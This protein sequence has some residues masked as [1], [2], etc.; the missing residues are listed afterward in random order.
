MT[1][2]LLKNIDSDVPD[3][4]SVLRNGRAAVTRSLGRSPMTFCLTGRFDLK[5]R[6]TLEDS[7]T[8]DAASTKDPNMLRHKR[9]RELGSCMK[10]FE[11]VVVHSEVNHMVSLG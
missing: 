7:Q 8:H 4:N 3:I 1:Y 11:M 9:L 5:A 2:A 10:V 6:D